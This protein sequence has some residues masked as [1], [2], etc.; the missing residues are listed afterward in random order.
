MENRDEI[1]TIS[2]MSLMQDL[3]DEELA[4]LCSKFQ[5]VYRTDDTFIRIENTML[6]RFK[7][8]AEALFVSN[9]TELIPNIKDYSWLFGEYR[10]FSILGMAKLKEV[11]LG[12]ILETT[13]VTSAKI[14]RD[15]R[16]SSRYDY[17]SAL[18]IR[19]IGIPIDVNKFIIIQCF[20]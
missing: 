10:E 2:I 18:G 17:V 6:P 5:E 15:F 9:I 3:T 14:A 13:F 19:Q 11:K 8:S 4:L 12:G 20:T 16:Y 1:S 7:I